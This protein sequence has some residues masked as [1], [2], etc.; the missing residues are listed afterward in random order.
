M[1]GRLPGALRTRSVR[2]PSHFFTA[3]G[4]LLTAPAPSR[5]TLW[6][7][8]QI[9]RTLG[10]P[11]CSLV[12]SSGAPGSSG[13]AQNFFKVV[14]PGVSCPGA[15]FAVG[16]SFAFWTPSLL[17][18]SRFFSS[19]L[20]KGEKR[21]ER[22]EKERAQKERRRQATVLRALLRAGEGQQAKR[23]W[24]GSTLLRRRRPFPPLERRILALPPPETPK[25]PSPP[26]LPPSPPPLKLSSEPF[27]LK[28]LL[29]KYG[30]GGEREPKRGR[31]IQGREMNL[32][33]PL[34]GHFSR[35]FFSMKW[36]TDRTEG[37]RGKRERVKE[38]YFFCPR[39]QSCC[40]YGELEKVEGGRE[41]ETL[42][43]ISFPRKNAAAVR[44]P[45]SCSHIHTV[46]LLL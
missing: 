41:G 2:A 33:P 26:L 25:S 3:T 6:G 40:C 9:S 34:I 30:Q 27:P 46:T 28:F 21:E 43:L 1:A 13:S 24:R 39:L 23:G 19:K 12:R 4:S 44:S 20:N 36:F 45:L 7:R 17:F 15:S 29:A 16:F 11:A 32:P 31:F 22:E 8:G 10:G 18:S 42:I 35:T 14:P 37:R 38:T 5:F